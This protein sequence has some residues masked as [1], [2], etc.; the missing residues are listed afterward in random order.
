[1]SGFLITRNQNAE[2][3]LIARRGPDLTRTFEVEGYH[4]SHYLLNVDDKRAPQPFVDGDIVC[5]LDGEIYSA[6]SAGRDPGT[7]I[8]LYRQHGDDFSRHLDGEFAVAIYDFSRRIMVLATDPFGTKPLFWSGTEAG[9]YSS[10]L[11]AAEQVAPNSVIVVDLDRDESHCRVGEPFDFDHQEKESY[12]DWI[13]AFEQAVRK[14]ATDGC[15][16]PLSAGY[17][18]GGIDCALRQLGL[19]YKAYS[20]E[21][22]ENLVMLRQRNCDGEILRMDAEDIAAQEALLRVH[23]EKASYRVTR[24]GVLQECD[25][26]EDRAC[27]GLALIHSLARREGRKVFLSGQ[28]GDETLDARRD[29]P[30]YLFPDKLR[31]WPDFSSGFQTAYLTKEDFIAGALGTEGRFPYL[32]REVVQEFLWLSS[33]LK[34]R[35]YKA[36]L[37]EYMMRCGYP[38]DEGVKTGFC[39]LPGSDKGFPWCKVAAD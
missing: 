3:R 27:C 23:A 10:G 14:R 25:M 35:N 26:L 4:F 11:G 19:E 22:E 28:G 18:S 37:H 8:S 1:M 15:Y 21:G 2:R 24:D 6:P 16:I 20:V 12:D 39:P 7:L 17:D 34:N 38:F 5:V 33:E 13:V 32:D 36:P 31:Q 30:G 29:W 9:S